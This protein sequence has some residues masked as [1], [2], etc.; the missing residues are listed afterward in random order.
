MITFDVRSDIVVVGHDSESADMSNPNGELYGVAYYVV[1]IDEKGNRWAHDY[2]FMNDEAAAIEFRDKVA[3][4]Y[5]KGIVRLKY[6]HWLEVEPVYGSEAY[7]QQ[8]G[9]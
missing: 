8:Y 4:T 7:I 3:N 9:G 5:N 1:M 6:E 2:R